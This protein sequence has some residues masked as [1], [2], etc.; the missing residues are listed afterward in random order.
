MVNFIEFNI[1]MLL[2]SAKERVAKQKIYYLTPETERNAK[3][4]ESYRYLRVSLLTN[5]T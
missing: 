4:Q 3:A 5:V 2:R 1:L